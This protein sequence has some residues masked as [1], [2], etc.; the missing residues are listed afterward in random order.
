MQHLMLTKTEGDVELFG[1]NNG[2]SVTLLAAGLQL[3]GALFLLELCVGD[4]IDSSECSLL[5]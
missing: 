2:G 5:C 1:S 3:P 4:S